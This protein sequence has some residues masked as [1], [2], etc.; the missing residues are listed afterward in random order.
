MANKYT[1]ILSDGATQFNVYD[2]EQNGPGNISTGRFIGVVNLTGGAGSNYFELEDDLTYRFVAGFTFTVSGSGTPSVNNDGTYTVAP[3][4]STYNAVT[5]RTSIPVVEAITT[6]GLP[7]GQITYSIPTTE[8]ATS[9]L[10]P[11]RGTLNYGENHISNLVHILENFSNTSAPTNPIEGQHWFNPIDRSTSTYKEIPNSPGNYEWIPDNLVS[12][13]THEPTGF[14]NRTDSIF[15]FVDGTG[16]F[17]IH[18]TGTSYDYYIAGVKYTETGTKNISI[19]DVEGLHFVYFDSTQTLQEI[20]SFDV[21]TL[22]RNGAF[23]AVIYWDAT[24][25]R[26]VYL[27]EERHSIIMDGDTHYHLHTTLGTQYMSGLGISN[28]NTAGTGANNTDVQFGVDNGVIRDEDIILD[29]ATGTPQVLTPYAYIPVFYRS[30]ANGVWRLK[31]ADAYP[32]IY[33][34]TAGWG[35]GSPQARPPYNALVGSP[36]VWS[37]VEVPEGDY[38]LM[39]Y[40]ATN[41]VNHPIIGIQGQNSYVDITSARDGA[42]NELNTLTGLPFQEFTPIA[43]I[44]FQC[45]SFYTNVPHARIQPAAGGDYVDWRSVENFVVGAVPTQHGNLGG[46]LKDD[47]PQYLNTTRGDARYYTQSQVDQ[48]II[49]DYDLQAGTGTASYTT[50][51]TFSSPTLGTATLQVFVNGVKQVEGGAKAYVSTAPNTVTFNAGAIPVAGDDVE[52]Y[53]FG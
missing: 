51:F 21:N 34:G 11:G 26:A 39:H 42:N 25:K 48:A 16:V 23:I 43:S 50:S 15:S 49:P 10:I 27:G 46:L 38:L 32:L 41:D 19:S 1:I 44:I 36:A 52:F 24:N 13:V 30:G 31:D 9:L 6:A 40:L 28:I 37:L 53:G 18:P 47:H 3:A 7:Y 22:F 35:G 2:H 29:I 5:R 45:S 12:Q 33:N 4:G 8:E 20:V 17:S 14:P